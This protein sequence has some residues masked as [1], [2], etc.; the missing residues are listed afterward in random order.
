M[1]YQF[2]IRKL[3]ENDF[4]VDLPF[5]D[6]NLENYE[7]SIKFFLKELNSVTTIDWANEN[8]NV[9]IIESQ[10]D[11]KNAFWESIK[12][13]VVKEEKRMKFLSLEQLT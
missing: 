11:D 1:K 5:P 13:I 6:T 2:K 8:E 3:E 9:I 10:L 12:K 7:S 4:N